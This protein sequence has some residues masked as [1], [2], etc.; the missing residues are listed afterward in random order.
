MIAP[1]GNSGMTEHEIAIVGGGLAGRIAALAFA[2]QGFDT[3]LIAR[4]DISADDIRTDRRTTALMDQSIGFLGTLDIWD[5]V[6]PETAPLVSMRI[7]DATGRL[8]HAPTVS[9]RAAEIGLEAFGYNIPNAPFLAILGD[10]LRAL[11]NVTILPASVVGAE[12]GTDAVQLHLADGTEVTAGLVIAADGRKSLIRDA[13]GIAVDSHS[14]PQTAIVLNFTH[15]R[16]HANVSTEFHTRTGPFTQVP[17]PGPGNRSSLVW[18]VTPEEA[19]EILG[20]PA[21]AL[22]R[23]IEDQMQSMLGKVAVDGTPQAWPLSAMTSRRFGAGRVALIGEA[24][25]VFPPIGAQGLNLSLRDIGTALDLA[26]QARGANGSLAIGEA[27]DRRRRTD[28]VSRTA[29]IDLFNRSLLSGF[30]PVQMLRA[31]GLHMLSAIPPLRYLA[32]NEGV[33]PGRGFRLL[34]EFLRP[35]FLRKEIRRK[36]A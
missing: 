35:D 19:E 13:A 33:A 9:F 34:P 27:Y 29:A 10:E 26:V 15:D 6:R 20:L 17:L 18:V 30:L 11:G 28:I 14:Y 24:A 1:T 32:M 2:R 36:H 22:D 7:I 5:K 4:D 31:A 3:V 21:P 12:L 16:P 8:L 25:H 23:R